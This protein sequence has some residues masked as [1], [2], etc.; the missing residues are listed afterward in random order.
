MISLSKPP[1]TW[2]AFWSDFSVETYDHIALLPENQRFLSRM[3]EL[4]GEN[5]SVLDAGC[6]TGNLT[7]HIVKKNKVTGL[8]FSLGMLGVAKKKLL[9]EKQA[10]FIEGNV[11]ELQFKDEIFDAVSSANVLFNLDKPEQALREMF[12]VL[13]PGGTLVISSQARDAFSKNPRDRV[14][15]DA[16]AA[17]IAREKVEAIWKYQVIMAENDG[18]KFAPSLEEVVAL[19][20]KIAFYE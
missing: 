18:F 3:S 15:A 14:L 11:Q 2:S 1:A 4:V 10:S 7:Q 8:D 6:G 16:M 5:K 13:K 20:E 9:H 12:R 17:G 19:L